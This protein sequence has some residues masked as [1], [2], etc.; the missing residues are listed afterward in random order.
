MG[1]N[2]CT[3]ISWQFS[4]LTVQDFLQIHCFLVPVPPASV[5]PLYYECSTTNAYIPP[6]L[7]HLSC[8]VSWTDLNTASESSLPVQSD[9]PLNSL[10]TC[11]TNVG[12]SITK[13][14]VGKKI[15]SNCLI[16]TEIFPI[17][18]PV[19]VVLLSQVS[20]MDIVFL[21]AKIILE[22]SL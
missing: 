15:Y 2:R 8:S 14:S 10:N 4:G 11:R 6:V 9:A 5:L 20:L 16:H 22:L 17:F 3:R 18:S 1:V 12:V 7:A 21:V 13:L 19:P